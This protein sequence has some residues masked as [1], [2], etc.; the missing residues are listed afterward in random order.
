[1]N[2]KRFGQIVFMLLVLLVCGAEVTLAAVTTDDI[3]ISV[4]NPSRGSLTASSIGD[5]T[6]GCYRVTLKATPVFANYGIT[7]TNITVQPLVDPASTRSNNPGIANNLT[8]TGSGTEFYFDLPERYQGAQV[9]A[10]FTEKSLT[11]ISSLSE[12]VDQYGCYKIGDSFTWD[13]R[14]N[15]IGTSDIPFKGVLDGNFVEFSLGSNPLFEKVDGAIIKNVFISSASVSTE[16]ATGAICCTATGATRIYNCGI[17]DGTVGSTGN[18]TDN[19]KT[20][21]CCGGLVGLL[22]GTSR[23]INCYSFA[24]ITGGNRVGGIVGYNNGTKNASSITTM[25]MNCMFYG[26]ITDGNKVSPV[27]GGNTIANTGANGLNTYT[28]YAYNKLHSE[29]SKAIDFFNCSLA[30]KEENLTRFEYYRQLLNG[31][32]KLAALYALNDATKGEGENNEMAKWVLDRDIAPY[33]I[34]KKQGKYPSLINYDPERTYDTESGRMISRPSYSED[35][36]NKGGT[37]GTL[38]I[39]INNVGSNAP[40]TGASIVNSELTPV[41]TDKDYDDYNFNYDKVQLPYYND[42]GTGNYTQNKVVTGWKITD[43]T[44]GSGDDVAEKGT[45]TPSDTWNGYNFADRKTYAKDIY[46]STNPRVFSQ[47]AYFDVPYGATSITIEPYWGTA[48][49]ICDPNYDV[50][51]AFNNDNN[52]GTNVDV[53]SAGTQGNSVLADG[54]PIYNVLESG[55][56]IFDNIETALGTLSGSTVYDN[57]L[58]LVGNLHLWNVPSGNSTPFTIMSVDLDKDNEPDY[59]L[60]YTHYN[61]TAV[62]PIRF[63]F[64]NVP[65]MAMTQK[66][67]TAGTDKLRNVPIFRPKGWFEV[68]NTCLISFSQLEYE[69]PSGFTKSDAPVILLGGEYEQF[70]STQNS[71]PTHTQYIHVGSNAYFKDFSNGTH[72]DGWSA[73]KHIPIS[74]TG[75][76]YDTFYL[77]GAYRPDAGVPEDDDAEGYISGGRFGE[78]AGAGQQQIDGNVRW[79]IYDAD[80]RDFYGGGVNDEKPI[81]GNIIVDIFNSHVTTYCGGPKFGNMQKEGSTRITWA[82]NKEGTRTS[83]R[84]KDIRENRTVTTNAYG[85]TFNEY[86]GAGYGGISYVRKRTQDASTTTQWSTW[87]TNYTNNKGKY[88]DGT[89]THIGDG[90]A[91]SKGGP[92]VAVDFDYEFF[93]WS[94]GKSG[95][96]FYNKYASLSLATTNNVESNLYGCNITNNFYGGGHLGKVDG[97]ITSNLNGCTV[98]GNVFGAGYSADKPTVP[99]TD[100]GFTTNPSIVE[101]IFNYGAKTTDIKNLELKQVATTALVDNQPAIELYGTTKTINGVTIHGSINTD[102]ELDKLG[103]VAGIVTLNMNDYTVG[104]TTKKTTITGNVFGGGESSAATNNVFVNISDNSTVTNVYGGGDQGDVG[105]NTTVTLKDN[106]EVNG[107][108][109]GGGNEAPVS[110]SATVN[111]E[112]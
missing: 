64:L 12:I 26:N 107:N 73:T 23:V 66:P 101:D 22:D 84:D 96:R 56:T 46:S 19:P 59:S 86:F 32:R 100:G 105:G 47:G 2:S 108:V 20:A 88:F 60:I 35:N 99:Y 93:V 10:T 90:T 58:V 112:E 31:N 21:N 89:T 71:A 54:Q 57:A 13:S 97:T 80:I 78:V 14:T 95:G 30:A 79:Q 8:V 9:T 104:S 69:N 111:I 52:S 11:E 50:V 16:G 103:V 98:G 61:R 85:C 65:G 38:K 5:L 3:K 34:L 44:I 53:L 72:S 83:Y 15:G 82:T 37:M 91:G 41:R 106:V 81:T 28:Y 68:T 42:V 29:D 1:M 55:K 17:L 62:S 49:Y 18:A 76:D 75:G 36:R 40:T 63:D 77:S 94:T 109:F 70:V 27:Y 4:T 67:S 39:I 92:G 48:A 43:V 7:T 33:P 110:G 45:F 74:A 25:V 24:T 51:V 102:V 6:A 87:E